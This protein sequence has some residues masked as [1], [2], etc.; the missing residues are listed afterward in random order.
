MFFV[1][2]GLISNNLRRENM[3]ISYV[4]LDDVTNRGDLRLC[5]AHNLFRYQTH[6]NV[7]I[8]VT[9]AYEK[10]KSEIKPGTMIRK[11]VR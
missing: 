10:C 9:R 5:N 7:T 1:N 11:F 4:I 8:L 3:V 6:E 2:A